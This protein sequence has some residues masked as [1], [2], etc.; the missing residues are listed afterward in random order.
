MERPV[1]DLNKIASQRQGNRIFFVMAHSWEELVFNSSGW[2]QIIMTPGRLHFSPNRRAFYFVKKSHVNQVIREEVRFGIIT[3]P[4]AKG[5]ILVHQLI[6]NRTTQRVLRSDTS[7]SES[8]SSEDEQSESE[9]ES[10]NT[11]KQD[12]ILNLESH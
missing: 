12:D 7:Y 3:H 5:F 1:F 6:L 11:S 8:E 10:A 2:K 4:E 9:S